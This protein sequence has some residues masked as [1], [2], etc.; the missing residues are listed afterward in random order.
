M[1]AVAAL[2]GSG[3]PDGPSVVVLVCLALLTAA[4][5][6]ALWQ[7]RKLWRHATS[8]FD[9]ADTPTMAYRRARVRAMPTA[10]AA[11]LVLV[12]GAWLFVA[13]PPVH[14]G[15]PN[16]LQVSGVG[17]FIIAAVAVF[18]VV[19]G[20][21]LYN[22]PQRLVPP[23]LRGDHGL[24]GR[25]SSSDRS[26]QPEPP[27]DSLTDDSNRSVDQGWVQQW[28]PRHGREAPLWVRRVGPELQV[29]K[30]PRLRE[31][32][33]YLNGNRVYRS[34]GHPEGPSSIPWLAIRGRSVYP[35]EGYPGGPS[36]RP[37][38]RIEHL[39]KRDVG[40]S[41]RPVRPDDVLGDH[42]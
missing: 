27:A 28:K 2:I 10:V 26:L 11:G 25:R 39:R 41:I 4:V 14:H 7:V 38:Y 35:A 33:Y 29:F 17:C 36:E 9:V 40:V 42:P 6:V 22:R 34:L 15:H 19:P 23:H 30:R 31:P 1:L 32:L 12:I 16:A 21:Y 13:S 5:P 3:S 18:V 24:A 20:I 8:F 37:L